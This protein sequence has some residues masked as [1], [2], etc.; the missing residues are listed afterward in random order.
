MPGAQP[1]ASW[2]SGGES[3]WQ[4]GDVWLGGAKARLDCSALAWV[5]AAAHSASCSQ[6]A[7]SQPPHQVN[8]FTAP[9]EDRLQRRA[10]NWALLLSGSWI[11]SSG[12]LPLSWN[13]QPVRASHGD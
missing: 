8:R 12:N 10:P 11:S 7:S 6:Q 13:R 5:K 3:C 9:A 4:L 1:T 2:V